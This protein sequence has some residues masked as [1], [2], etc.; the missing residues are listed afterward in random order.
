MAITRQLADDYFE[1]RNHVLGGL[2]AAFDTED[3]EGA[4]QHSIRRLGQER[5]HV[6]RTSTGDSPAAQSDLI[7]E[8]TT[9]PSDWPRED[10]AVYEQ[11][12]HM[13]IHSDAV[14]DSTKT[15]PKWAGKRIKELREEGGDPN[16]ISTE[17][18][19]YMGWSSRGRHVIRG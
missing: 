9:T 19:R 14:A 15:A 17:A 4:I 8:D 3:R 12:L 13:L 2:W 10:L 11:A 6:R 1:P 16:F 5:A 18:R 7:D